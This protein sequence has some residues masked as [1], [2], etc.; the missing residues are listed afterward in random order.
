MNRARPVTR[1]ELED[2]LEQFGNEL[3][4]AVVDILAPIGS[5]ARR[6][7]QQRAA[8]MQ[9]HDDMPAA[10]AIARGESAADAIQNRRGRR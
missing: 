3:V 4:K 8:E 9:A 1:G 5:D 10:D 7:A 6:A 2:F